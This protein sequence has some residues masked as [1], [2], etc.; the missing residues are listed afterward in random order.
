MI[1]T[2]FA[3]TPEP[4]DCAVIVTSQRTA[5][6]GAYADMAGQML[7]LAHQQSECAN[8]THVQGHPVQSPCAARDGL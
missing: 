6:K 5:G 7:A 1:T 4:V 2:M 3:Q 8:H